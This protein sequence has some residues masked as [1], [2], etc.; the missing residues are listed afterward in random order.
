MR[1]QIVA[2]TDQLT[3][4]AQMYKLTES[5]MAQR[6]GVTPQTYRRALAGEPVSAAF[7][8]GVSIAFGTPF[9]SI[10]LVRGSATAAA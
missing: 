9:E 3:H 4:L 2:D 6:I 7:V 10:F 8:A 5:K 1:K